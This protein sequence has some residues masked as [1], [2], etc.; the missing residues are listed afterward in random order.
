M[1]EKSAQKQNKSM[2][3]DNM[4]KVGSNSAEPTKKSPIDNVIDENE[5]YLEVLTSKLMSIDTRLTPVMSNLPPEPAVKDLADVEYSG[6]SSTVDRL[7]SQRSQIRRLENILDRM[8]RDL[9]V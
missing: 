5:H 1:E 8:N 7:M 6:S 2:Y 4:T 3:T 9:E